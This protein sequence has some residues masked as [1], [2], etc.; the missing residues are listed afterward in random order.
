MYLISVVAVVVISGLL[1]VMGR[2]EA[3]WFIDLPSLLIILLFDGMLLFASGLAKDLNNAFRI[4]LKKGDGAGLSE[5]KR[6]IEAVI[7]VRRTSV[8]AGAFSM[9]FG[10]VMAMGYL[11]TP[12]MLGSTLAVA[13]L[14]LLYALA[15]DLILLPLEARLRLKQQNLLQD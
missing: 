5:I 2:G 10:L 1:M 13:S 6:A 4:G 14:T 9:I 11:T 8:A 15:I 12:E 3:A 7:L